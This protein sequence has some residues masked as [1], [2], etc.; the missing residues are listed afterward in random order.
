MKKLVK[1]NL[2]VLSIFLLIGCQKEVDIKKL[3]NYWEIKKVENPNGGVK[4]YTFNE[5]IDFIEV[6]GDKGFRKKVKPQLDGTF[7]VTNDTEIFKI[8]KE[9]GVYTINYSTQYANW[10]EE[11]EK[12][13]DE[14]LVVRNQV[15]LIYTYQKYE[16]NFREI[17]EGKGD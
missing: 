11:I 6:E 15:G 13:T 12:L 9:D 1:Y 5:T 4:E 8:S 7:L 16:N 10:K 3:N 2:F 14:T 17:M